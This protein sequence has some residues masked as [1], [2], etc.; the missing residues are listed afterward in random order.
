MPLGVVKRSVSAGLDFRIYLRCSRWDS[1]ARAYSAFV[2]REHCQVEGWFIHLFF[3][4][5]KARIMFKTYRTNN[6]GLRRCMK[7]P[8]HSYDIVSNGQL[9]VFGNHFELATEFE[10]H[11]LLA[12]KSLGPGEVT[13]FRYYIARHIV[14]ESP[15]LLFYG[16]PAID[17][18]EMRQ[19]GR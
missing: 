17:V 14:V 18:L 13:R 4:V 6:G 7:S 9:G 12:S 8:F 15:L 11:F 3:L 19:G 2:G 10:W 5:T 16:G 1:L